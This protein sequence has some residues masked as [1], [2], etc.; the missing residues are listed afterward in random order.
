MNTFK[1][2]ITTLISLACALLGLNLAQAQSNSPLAGT[3]W[4]LETGSQSYYKVE[5]RDKSILRFVK[6]DGKEIIENIAK[7]ECKIFKYSYITVDDLKGLNSYSFKDLKKELA[8]KKIFAN[9]KYSSLVTSDDCT[10]GDIFIAIDDVTG[11]YVVND[12]E[13]GF[14]LADMYR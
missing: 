2:K 11:V 10:N 12:T 13:G 14:F 1:L 4:K 5:F 7:S 8:G 3:N 9:K 6:H